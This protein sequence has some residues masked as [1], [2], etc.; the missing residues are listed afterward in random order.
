MLL[1]DIP[2]AGARG[3]HYFPLFSIPYDLMVS[4]SVN[5][6]RVRRPPSSLCE[7]YTSIRRIGI[8]HFESGY[9]PGLFENGSR[10]N[11]SFDKSVPVAHV[12]TGSIHCLTFLSNMGLPIAAS[13]FLTAEMGNFLV[14]NSLTCYFLTSAP[15]GA[16][17]CSLERNK[18]RVK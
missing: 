5:V 12:L 8:N 3:K 7:A 4:S 2:G 13:Q 16:L 6:D 17:S 15:L 18:Y 10:W 14:L 1:A 9:F 11:H